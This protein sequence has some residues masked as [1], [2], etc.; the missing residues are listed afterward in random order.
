MAVT[1]EALESLPRAETRRA[2]WQ[3]AVR[4]F[5]WQ[6]PLGAVCAVIILIMLVVALAADLLAPYEALATD[7]GAMH[8]A[9]SAEP[10]G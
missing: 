3:K 4:D 7:Y 8:A 5:V 1:K 2:R 6:R 9:P 10:L